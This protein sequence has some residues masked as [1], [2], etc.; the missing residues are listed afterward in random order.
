MAEKEFTNIG[1]MIEQNARRIQ[2][3]AE[4]N[5]KAFCLETGNTYIPKGM[6]GRQ[7]LEEKYTACLKRRMEEE[8]AEAE[9]RNAEKREQMKQKKIALL[10]EALAKTVPERYRGAAMSDFKDSQQKKAIMDGSCALILGDNSTGKTR[11]KWALC[12]HWAALGEGFKVVK[13]QKL[14]SEIKRQDEPYDYMECTYG[15][16]VR[17]LVIDEMD[18]IFESKADFVYMNYLIDYRYEWM[19]QTVVIGNGTVESFIETL[20]QS[21]FARL[22][23]EGGQSIAFKGKDWRFPS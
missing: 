16:S 1:E 13:A 10:R 18:K 23:G 15:R 2:Q 8:K 20:G 11:F 17:H 7:T 21:I 5:L 22:A 3:E 19:L 9:K 4:E 12:D 14:L 6:E